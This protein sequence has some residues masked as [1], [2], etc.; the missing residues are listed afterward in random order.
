MKLIRHVI[1]VDI[2]SEEKL[3]INSLNGII[4]KI[5]VPVY[6]IFRK[7]RGVEEIVPECEVEVAL[8]ESLKMRG[9]LSN[10]SK[11]EDV[12]KEKL[13]ARLREISTKQ[14]EACRSITFIP[15]YNC[16]FRCPYCFEGEN[17]L[18]KGNYDT[19]SSGCRIRIG[20]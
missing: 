11:D 19:R 4:D 7:W 15:S 9:Y 5:S 1:P 8:F 12:V 20:W 3:M 13:V 6:E 18:K 10:S 14:R 17:T 2:N 16:N